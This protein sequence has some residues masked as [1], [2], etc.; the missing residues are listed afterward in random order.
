VVFTFVFDEDAGEITIV[1]EGVPRAEDFRALA[2]S[3]TAD[4]RYRSGLAHL[5]DC[6]R[7]QP[8]TLAPEGIQE[9]VAPLIE[10]DWNYPPRAVAIVAPDPE[11]F[12]RAVLA[13]AH[14]GGG[15]T[16]N[17]RIFADVAEARA[18]LETQPDGLAG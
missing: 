12:N 14:M 11:V 2:A 16:A 10:R 9:Q 5:V 3:L 8:G 1:L 13:R 7:L 17:R 4:P 18:W 15:S 6:S